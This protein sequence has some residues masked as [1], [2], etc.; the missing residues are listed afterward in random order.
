MSRHVLFFVLA[1]LCTPVVS[2]Q[3]A[4]PAPP[5]ALSTPPL[6]SAPDPSS[7]PTAEPEDGALPPSEEPSGVARSS[8][9]RLTFG[10]AGGLAGGVGVGGFGLV[11]GLALNNV[12]GCKS[13]ECALWP[14]VLGGSG[15]FVGIPLGTYL[16]GK[17]WGGRGTF[18]AAMGG[19]L[20]GW[21]AGLLSAMLLSLVTSESGAIYI[22]IFGLPI[23]G[24]AVG[25][26]ISHADHAPRPKPSPRASRL[27]VLPVA[28]Y[29][30]GGARV[31]LVGSF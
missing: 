28:G 11:S 18:M 19:S 10:L 9:L 2:A 1:L 3:E 25:Y 13:L 27:Q 6:V 17:L 5:P 31:G 26:A 29:S 4:Q 24:A 7:A 15:L 16:A 30:S 23:V 20:A 21:G 12:S 14:G 22:P 8:A